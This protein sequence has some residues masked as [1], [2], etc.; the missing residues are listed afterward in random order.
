MFF[1]FSTAFVIS[2]LLSIL[3]LIVDSICLL[4]KSFL[5]YYSELT[6]NQICVD[7]FQELNDNVDERKGVKNYTKK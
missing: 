7:I 2:I 5:L 1:M 4:V 6:Y 3:A